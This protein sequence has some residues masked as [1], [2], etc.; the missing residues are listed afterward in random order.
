MNE[1]ASVISGHFFSKDPGENGNLKLHE[2]LV[3]AVFHADYIAS[4]EQGI[5][6]TGL[7]FVVTCTKLKFTIVK[8]VIL[9]ISYASFPARSALSNTSPLTISILHI[10]PN[11][12]LM[13][14]QET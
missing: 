5:Q 2:C 3:R 6:S 8:A 7:K 11:K 4:V 9:V 14:W 13:N 10:K 12:I 1:R